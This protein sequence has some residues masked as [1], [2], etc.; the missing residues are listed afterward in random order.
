MEIKGVKIG[1]KRT[2]EKIHKVCVR[3]YKKVT[4]IF[5]DYAQVNS[6]LQET[7]EA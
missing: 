3:A 4:K 2:A 5:A 1:D 7:D 6:A